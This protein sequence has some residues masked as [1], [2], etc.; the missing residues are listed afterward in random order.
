MIIHRN[1]FPFEGGLSDIYDEN[2]AEELTE[3]YI[4]SN[5]QIFVEKN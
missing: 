2:L 4:I 1:I 5:N 3:S